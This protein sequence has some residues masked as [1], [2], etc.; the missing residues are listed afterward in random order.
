VNNS[1]IGNWTVLSGLWHC[2]VWHMVADVF[3]QHIASNLVQ[4]HSVIFLKTSLI[5][6]HCENF[7]SCYT[8][9]QHKV[10]YADVSL[11]D[12]NVEKISTTELYFDL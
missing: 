5:I 2:A 9:I 3:G 1:I 11:K 4:L 6:H 7:T 12:T 10:L 8:H